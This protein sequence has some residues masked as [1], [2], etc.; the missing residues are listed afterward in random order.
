M[1]TLKNICSEIINNTTKIWDF[2]GRFDVSLTT[3][4]SGDSTRIDK[5]LSK[6]FDNVYDHRSIKKSSKQEKMIAKNFSGLSKG[7]YLYTSTIDNITLYCAWWP[8]GDNLKISIR[9]GL[10]SLDEAVL[11]EETAASTIKNIFDIK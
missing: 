7:Q 1:K 4:D 3:F 8:W 6:L 5:L 9:F 11:D 2:D 10:F